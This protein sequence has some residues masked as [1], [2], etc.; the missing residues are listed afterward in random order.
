MPTTIINQ[1]YKTES[2]N[3][4]LETLEPDVLKDQFLEQRL[5]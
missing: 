3:D 5:S 4:A 1:F 2:K